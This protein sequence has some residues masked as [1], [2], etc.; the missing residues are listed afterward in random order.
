[1][2]YIAYARENLDRLLSAIFSSTEYGKQT[3][4]TDYGNLV[5]DEFTTK[6]Y[7]IF[8]EGYS[9]T[10]RTEDAGVVIN[11]DDSDDEI[12]KKFR[13]ILMRVDKYN[14]SLAAAS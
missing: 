5:V 3:L 10:E 14:K 9:F 2:S 1:M 8:H 6:S 11:D 7:T 13:V 12:I 4:S